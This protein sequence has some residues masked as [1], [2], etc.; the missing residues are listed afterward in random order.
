MTCD[1]IK[2]TYNMYSCYLCCMSGE[3]IEM[4]DRGSVK[5]QKSKRKDMID[6]S[7][8]DLM[9]IRGNNE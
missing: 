7:E 9:I 4:D 2:V 3:M 8:I 6:I 1:V 5:C